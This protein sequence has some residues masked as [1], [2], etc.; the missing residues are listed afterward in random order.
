[1]F[2]ITGM[3]NKRMADIKRP[4]VGE[5]LTFANCPLRALQAVS[6]RRM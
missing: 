2:R 6:M 3:K 4:F 1:M 5:E